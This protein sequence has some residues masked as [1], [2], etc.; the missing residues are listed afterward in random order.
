MVSASVSF[1]TLTEV[2]AGEQTESDL[3]GDAGVLEGLEPIG[4]SKEET[5]GDLHALTETQCECVTDITAVS[6]RLQRAARKDLS[7]FS[8]YPCSGSSKQS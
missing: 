1:S 2:R 4:D 7:G 8:Y 3:L 5:P 6:K